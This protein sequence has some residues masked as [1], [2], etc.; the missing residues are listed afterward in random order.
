M[1]KQFLFVIISCLLLFSGYT[2]T[3]QDPMPALSRLV[4][5]A[6]VQVQQRGEA[7][8]KQFRMPGSKWRQGETYIFVLDKEGNMLVHPDP[9]MEGDNQL[10]LT[11]IKG[12]PI[13]QGLINTV[14]TF[15]DRKEGWYHY[16]WPVPG[17][18]LPR[19]KSSFVQQVQAP[20][21]NRYIVG[22]GIY[23]DRMERAFVV[24]IVENA[25][26]EI[27]K[28]GKDAFPV[29]HDPKGPFIAKDAYVFVTDTTGVELVNPIFPN[30]EGRSLIDLKDSQGKYLVREMLLQ[31]KSGKSGWVN[32]MW[33][34]PGE[35][36]PTQKSTY[37]AKA[38]VGNGWVLVG[39]GVHLADA[40]KSSGSLL[41][42]MTAAE[43]KAT[44]Q[45]AAAVFS[46]KGEKAFPEFR[47]M[48]SKWFHDDTY[49][50]VWT[51]NGVRL[52][53]AA[54]SAHEG[55]NV[56]DMKDALGRPIGK[57][58]MEAGS[59][60]SGEGW[61]HYMYPEPGDIFPTWKSTY[62]KR[63]TFPSGIQYLIGC[64]IYNMQ[65]DQS[66]IEDVVDRASRL[67]A[68]KGNYA[69]PALRDKL[70]SFVF[71]DTYVFVQSTDGTELVNAAQPSFEGKNLIDLKDLKGRKIIRDQIQ[72]AMEKG[73]AWMDCYWYT[74]GDNRPALKRTYVR[75]VQYKGE[76]YIVGSGLYIP[77]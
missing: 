40:P 31:L 56:S 23:N 19:W 36:I 14:Y 60:A 77:E 8:F 24:D 53:H 33:P 7:A 44:V 5:E 52:F 16:Q 43:L 9:D 18:M 22:S 54:D 20:S 51:M 4:K 21:G 12:K 37:V 41:K 68:E 55:I 6:S 26:A 27:E 35:S 3:V 59:G 67:I 39:C 46:A 38:R 62:V 1:K 72:L 58:F 13:I 69:F 17:G 10:Y 50:F 76:T 42:K 28:N 34:K 25:V 2:Q 71:M 75:K 15:P 57:M 29:L 66:F 74:P 70:G 32:Y 61:I 48:G 63:V 47:K 49:F 65:M 73:A 45:E 11:D 30:L 64:G